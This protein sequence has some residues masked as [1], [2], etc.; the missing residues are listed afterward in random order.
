[1]ALTILDVRIGHVAIE[2]TDAALGFEP[3]GTGPL[4]GIGNPADYRDLFAK[5]QAEEDALALPWVASR[6]RHNRF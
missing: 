6:P 5:A 2:A 3:E 4:A 1:M